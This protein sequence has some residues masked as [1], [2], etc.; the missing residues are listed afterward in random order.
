MI[1]LS[2]DEIFRQ[3]GKYLRLIYRWWNNLLIFVSFEV[4]ELVSKRD[5]I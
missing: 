3:K 2:E 5:D 4:N 1:F